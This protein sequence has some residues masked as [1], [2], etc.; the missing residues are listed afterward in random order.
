[1]RVMEYRANL[2]GGHLKVHSQPGKGVRVSCY[3]PIALT[4][5][6]RLTKH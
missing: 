1:L 5:E 4:K 2:L 3:F 6:G